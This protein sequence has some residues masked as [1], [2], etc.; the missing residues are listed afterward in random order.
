MEQGGTYTCQEGAARDQVTRL[1]TVLRLTVAV[2]RG[3]GD[4]DFYEC[5]VRAELIK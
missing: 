1:S 3:G 5:R 2:A 4:K